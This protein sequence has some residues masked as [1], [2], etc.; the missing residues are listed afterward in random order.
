MDTG[1]N[2]ESRVFELHEEV[3][4]LMRWFGDDGDS[5]MSVANNITGWQAAAGAIGVFGTEVQLSGAN[6]VAS[7]DF[8]D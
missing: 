8:A 7:A 6:D 3:H 2:T 1:A 5:T 4:S